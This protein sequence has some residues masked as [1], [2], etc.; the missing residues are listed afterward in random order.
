MKAFK[1]VSFLILTIFPSL[2]AEPVDVIVFVHGTLKPADFSFGSII[3]IMGNNIANTLYSQA[4]TY[5]RQD[6]YFHQNQAMQGLGLKPI[7][8]NVAQPSA[9]QCIARM[10]ELQFNAYNQTN[11][12]LYYT[13]GW[14]G[15]LNIEERAKEGESFYKQLKTELTKIEGPNKPIRLH[16]IGYSHGG[17]VALNLATARQND[18]D[19]KHSFSIETL[20]LLGMPVQKATDHLVTDPLFKKIYHIYSTED[21][22]QTLDIFSPNQ[23]FS[24]RTF[25]ERT[26]FRPPENLVQIRIRVTRKVRG[27]HN[28]SAEDK[29]GHSFLA[30]HKI[31]RIHKDPQHTE[32]WCFKWGAVWYRDLFPLCPLPAVIFIPSLIHAVENTVPEHQMITIDYVPMHQGAVLIPVIK[33]QTKTSAILTEQETQQLYALAQEYQPQDFSLEVQQ[34]KIEKYLK[35]AQL[36]LKKRRGEKTIRTS[37]LLSRIILKSR[38]EIASNRIPYRQKILHT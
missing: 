20:V 30:H 32:L 35:K 31:R 6:P 12:R 13:F 9:A 21:A 27:L 14:N 4:N 26:N 7:A 37:R 36:D 25:K 5:I 8:M 16:V 29:T 24:E 15:L 33:D 2:H 38:K 34:D 11:Q 19:Q 22:I 23:F 28:I 3:K 17:N 18:P 1:R 10:F